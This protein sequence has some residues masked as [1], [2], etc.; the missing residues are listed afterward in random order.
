[1]GEFDTIDDEL[2]AERLDYARVAPLPEPPTVR[3]AA[4]DGAERDPLLAIALAG[5]LVLVLISTGVV[6]WWFA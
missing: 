3:L 4:R 6:L 2:F 5:L 1:M